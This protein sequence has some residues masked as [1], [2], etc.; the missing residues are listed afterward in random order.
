MVVNL[1]VLISVPE[2]EIQIYDVNALI[3]PDM[4]DGCLYSLERV[5]LEIR[6]TSEERRC[7]LT[8]V[9]MLKASQKAWSGL[10]LLNRAKSY[11]HHWF[12]FYCPQPGIFTFYLRTS[13]Q[14]S[15]IN[16]TRSTPR[17]VSC[18]KDL[19]LWID[20]FRYNFENDEVRAWTEGPIFFIGVKR[21]DDAK[22]PF[23]ICCFGILMAVGFPPHASSILVIH[24]NSIYIY[25][26]IYILSTYLI[27]Q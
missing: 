13:Y 22:S 2:N 1:A 15:V 14:I 6:D 20:N 18:A 9:F 16:P 17:Q 12:W 10:I 26:Y 11:H 8:W 23:W 27:L 25:S 19:P 21:V 24:S 5:R 3:R 4:S 7:L